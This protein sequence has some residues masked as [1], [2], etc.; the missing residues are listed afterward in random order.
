MASRTSILTM[1]NIINI[2]DGLWTV[3]DRMTHGTM[4]T[5]EKINVRSLN[6]TTW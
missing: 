6:T 1:I 2:L 3:T 5:Q 4:I